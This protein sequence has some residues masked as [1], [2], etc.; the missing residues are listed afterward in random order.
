M[1]SPSS[2]LRTPIRAGYNVFLY[3]APN[4]LRKQK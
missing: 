1:I 3:P 4:I 2:K